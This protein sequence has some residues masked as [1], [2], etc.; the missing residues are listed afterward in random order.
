[1]TKKYYRVLT[2]CGHVGRNGY[3]PIQ[4]AIVA[5][6]GKEAAKIARDMPRVKHHHK[7]AILKV[8]E[9]SKSIYKEIREINAND[10]YLHCHSIQEQRQFDLTDR[11]IP[12][13]K[14]G[15]PYKRNKEKST[16]MHGKINIR[17]PKQYMKNVFKLQEAY[18]Y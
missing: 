6:T 7:D 11:L 2:K 13:T 3:V 10:P 9:I 15:T 8:E 18:C 5:E 14:W 1:M 16:Y 17:H 4:F 12:E